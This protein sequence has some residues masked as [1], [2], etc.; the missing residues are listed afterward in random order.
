[1]VGKRLRSA[2]DLDDR[3]KALRSFFRDGHLADSGSSSSC[4][5]PS[6]QVPESW[7]CNDSPRETLV[8]A[9]SPGAAGDDVAEADEVRPSPATPLASASPPANG[10]FKKLLD[11]VGRDSEVDDQSQRLNGKDTEQPEKL[12][13]P[14]TKQG[15]VEFMDAMVKANVS[16]ND[17]S[18][19]E[20]LIAVVKQQ[21]Q[22]SSSNDNIVEAPTVN[23]LAEV[24]RTGIFDVRDS[25]G[26]N[27]SRVHK[28]GTDARIIW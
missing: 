15:F 25:V 7:A 12:A 19:L 13:F 28:K 8:V 17:W 5:S 24:A 1:M 16:E 3:K 9:D 23:K 6:L 10:S 26:Q 21:H 22:K 20:K 14:N 2:E 18:E 11:D 4:L 27:F